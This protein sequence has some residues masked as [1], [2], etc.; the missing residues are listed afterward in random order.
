MNI[1]RKKRSDAKKELA[2]RSL[3]RWKGVSLVF[4]LGV[5]S[6]DTYALFRVLQHWKIYGDVYLSLDTVSVF[7]IFTAAAMLNFFLIR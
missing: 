1:K 4:L 5:L 2:R 7:I 3:R 6:T